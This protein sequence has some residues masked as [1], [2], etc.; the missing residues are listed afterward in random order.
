MYSKVVT[1]KDLEG[2]QSKGIF[3]KVRLYGSSGKYKGI[4]DGAANLLI[5]NMYYSIMPFMNDIVK[6]E[7]K[8][9]K[10]GLMRLSGEVLLE[11][12]YDRI[13]PLSELVY[14]VCKDGKLGFMNLKGEVE[15][16]FIYEVP[17]R[18][19][20]FSE[21]LACVLK[22][23]DNGEVKYGYINHKNQEILPFNFVLDTPFRNT[24]IIENW[25]VYKCGYG[26]SY[27][28]EYYYLSLDGTITH[29]ETEHIEDDSWWEEH[30]VRYALDESH[31]N[32]DDDWLD[33][34]EGDSSNRWNID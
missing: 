24:D 28:R 26:K 31:R 9:H 21:G 15:I 2:V 18:E 16:P 23:N 25:K 17:D 27:T 29:F 10:F 19:V 13:D 6:V 33:V 11:P 7:Y 30:E 32:E 4:V 3:E 1:P 22:Q 14:A 34:F 5:P 12:I 8:G 20:I